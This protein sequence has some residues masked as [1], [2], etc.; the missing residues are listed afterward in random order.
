M[1]PRARQAGQPGTWD[2]DRAWSAS[3]NR[4][5]GVAFSRQLQ[6]RRDPASVARYPREPPEAARTSAYARPGFAPEKADDRA[7]PPR[8]MVQAAGRVGGLRRAGGRLLIDLGAHP[9]RADVSREEDVERLV[10]AAVDALDDY[11]VLVNNAGIG[12]HAPLVD[13]TPE[14]MLRVWRTNVL[15][16]MLVARA[17][18]RHF[19]DRGGGNI[20]NVGSTA[21]RRG[22]AGGTAYA[23]S[24]FALRGMSECWRAELRGSDVRV[25]HVDPSEV[26]TGFGRDGDE[27]ARPRNETKLRPAEIAHTIASLLEMDDRGFI[28]ELSVWATN[29]R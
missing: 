27:P 7:I 23:S 13:T 14:A 12:A 20:V 11:D 9:V 2:G 26:Q 6:R 18:A 24:K 16:A 17:S 21:G 3:R 22:Y 28:P 8:R 19:V 10:R 4:E 15:G 25:M 1:A 29:P 5:H